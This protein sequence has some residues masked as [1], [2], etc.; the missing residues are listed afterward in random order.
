MIGQLSPVSNIP[1]QSIAKDEEY[2]QIPGEM[3]LGD[4]IYVTDVTDRA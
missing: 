3:Y 1:P 4:V 2:E